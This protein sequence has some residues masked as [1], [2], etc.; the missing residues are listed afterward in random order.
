MIRHVVL[1][2]L[3][4]AAQGTAFKD[5]LLGC[6]NLVSGMRGFE[7]GL[8]QAGLAAS[9]QVCLIATFDDADALQQYQ[10]HPTHVAMSQRIAAWR[11]QRHVLDYEVNDSAITGNHA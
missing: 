5:A 4:D 8:R 2:E 7:V 9:V 6:R 11:K 3:H 1:W 10:Q